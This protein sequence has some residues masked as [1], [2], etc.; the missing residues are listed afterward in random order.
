[1]VNSRK[2]NPL[3]VLSFCASFFASSLWAQTDDL[4]APL[5]I[6]IFGF[7]DTLRGVVGRHLNDPDLW[8][9]VLELNAISTSAAVV[10]GTALKLPVKQVRAADVALA[11]SLTAI[12][13]ANAEGAQ[14]FAPRE[15]GEA[16]AS[17]GTAVERRGIGAW[18]EVVSYSDIASLL[19]KE[20]LDISI[21]QRDQ[22]AEAIVSDVQGRV[23]G[24]APRD[25]RWSGRVINDILVEFERV[26]TLSD[27]TTQVT[28]RD[29]SRLR[30]NANSNAT[31]QRMRSD[32]LTGT[33]VTKVSLVSGDFYALLNQLSDK[34]EFEVDV[35]G[36]ETTT[37]SSDFWIKNDASGARFVNYDQEELEINNGSQTIELGQNEGLF[38]S[39]QGV[40]RA[41]VLDAPGLVAPPLDQILYDGFAPLVWTPFEGAE[42]Y[43]VEVAVDPGFNQMQVSEWG[44][45]GTTLDTSPLP[46][47]TYHWRVAALDRLG[48]PGQWSTA[49]SFI[50]REDATPPFLTLLLP[51]DGQIV[52][53]PQVEVLGASEP[54]SEVALNG[55][56]IKMGSDGSFIMQTALVPGPNILTLRAVDPAGNESTVAQTVIY[57]PAAQ[58]SISLSPALPRVDGA[59]AT[60][61][62]ELS[63]FAASTAATGAEVLVKSASGVVGR[64]VV[65]AAG[66]IS[67]SVPA[68]VTPKS[69]EIAVLGPM[70]GIEGQLDFEVVR[71]QVA[72]VIALDIPPPGAIDIPNIEM[73]G[74][75]GDA[76]QMSVNGI[77]VPLED[78]VFELVLDLAPGLNVFDLVATD[79]VGNVTATRV[80][81]VY[82]IE[83]P[84]VQDIT[85]TRPQGEDGPIE[86]ALIAT[87]AS[88]LRQAAQYVLQVGT[89]ER[90]GFLRCDS[91]AGAC[92]ATLPGEPGALQL[93]EVIVED[94]AGNAAFR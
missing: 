60:R 45:R 37:K 40:E 31:I 93:I 27:S 25:P 89:V 3:C 75:A 16:L 33:E 80:Q 44:V 34:T 51:G 48:L 5:E 17:R 9:Y 72:P 82:D 58:I 74:N 94:Y 19:A 61:S 56:P 23:E 50:L 54:A 78:G 79:P 76:A 63:V 91:A 64:T 57:R 65:G 87:D 55:A 4:N 22:S 70:G 36:V 2:W 81:T 47:R 46:P 68:D 52:T 20:A 62:S 35:P 6:V 30:L 28:F 24:R 1:M 13:R 86:I 69:Y 85:V 42:A 21:A 12:Q 29:L 14:V 53:E 11:K 26:R 49:Q 73:I 43:W 15:I 84:E 77:D 38:L 10:P 39:F 67:F 7:D 41:D 88:G 66:A 32:P 83:P 90:E 18:V 59:L 8:P 71:D 92:R